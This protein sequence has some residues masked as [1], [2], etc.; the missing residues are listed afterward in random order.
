MDS[1]GNRL[2]PH[3]CNRLFD[4]LI[5]AYYFS[6]GCL[7][8]TAAEFHQRRFNT[9]RLRLVIR[10]RFSTKAACRQIGDRLQFDHT[11]GGSMKKPPLRWREVIRGGLNV[12]P[13]LK[14]L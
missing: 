1:S 6:G 5:E 7:V 9:Y 13:P 4:Y 12:Q 2:I 3:L 14:Y 11:G 10:K 8:R